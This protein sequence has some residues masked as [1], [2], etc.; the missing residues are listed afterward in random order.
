MRRYWCLLLAAAVVCSFTGSARAQKFI[1]KA[2]KFEGDPE[3]T[4]Q[5]LLTASGIK[6]GEVLGFTDMNGYSQ[7]LLSS[8]AFAA[9]A[10]KFDGVDLT[11]SLAPSPDLYP[12]RIDNLPLAPGLDLD[13]K[14]HALVPLYH[15]KVPS[16][17]GLADD[18]RDAL[19]KLLAEQGITAT[20]AAT[21]T[22]DLAAH[23]ISAIVYS[24]TSPS[25]SIGPV[26]TVGV[27]PE[28]MSVVQNAVNE[29]ATQ[30]FDTA[31]SAGNLRSAV[32]LVYHDRGYA[33][34]KVQADRAGA[35]AVSADAIHIPYSI[36]VDPGRVYRVAAIH[37][38]DGA[39]LTQDDIA[40]IIADR[41]G[42][43][44]EGVRIRTVW[45]RLSAGYKA[46]GRLD[47]KITP[48]PQ[49]DD[50][51]GTVSYNVDVD[52]GPVYHLGLV[53]F[54]NVSDEMRAL[55]THYWQM[56]P[57]DVFDE[58]YVSQFIYKAQQQD[59]RLRQSLTGV[60]VGFNAMA[61]PQTHVVNVVIRLSR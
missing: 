49:F 2:I 13:A 19:V 52:P 42:A 26:Q 53:K 46:Q 3:Y 47:C 18:V 5:E 57:G 48:H 51:A 27:S 16:D 28:L 59:P 45:A 20:V 43:P 39:P 23:K 31:N 55:L 61:D 37:L 21:P 11:F 40:K 41:P 35:P 10:F 36:T 60:K 38:P 33:A 22:S 15:G 6:K 32:E 24:I 50:A 56:M 8:G 30:P 14:L 58:S 1:P 34:V 4:A 17:G 7:K 44:T 25:V 9:V 12:M 29:I 54:D